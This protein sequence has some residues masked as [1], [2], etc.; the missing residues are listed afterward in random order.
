[1]RIRPS[2][3]D[4]AQSLDELSATVIPPVTAHV[5]RASGRLLRVDFPTGPAKADPRGALVATVIE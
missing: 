1:M 4:V 3:V 5:D 2:L